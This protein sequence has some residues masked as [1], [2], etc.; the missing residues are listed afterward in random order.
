MTFTELRKRLQSMARKEAM[1]IADAAKVPRSTVDKLRMGIGE[2]PR[3][4]TIEPLIAVLA[5]RKAK[6]A[7]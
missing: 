1:A 5:K 2:N 4:T 3:V 7:A 6:E